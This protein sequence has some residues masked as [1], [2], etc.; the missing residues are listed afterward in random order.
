MIRAKWVKGRAIPEED[1][2]WPD[3]TVVYVSC[4]LVP[5]S[6]TSG[7]ADQ[8]DDAESVAKWLAWYE[9]L[10]PLVYAPGEEAE[11][12]AARRQV[13]DYSRQNIDRCIEGVFE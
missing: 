8:F 4:S 3:G 1:V 5:D 2:D 11:I 10:E 7:L 13:A 9:S 6:D 12:E